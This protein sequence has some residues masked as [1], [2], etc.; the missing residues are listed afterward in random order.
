[1]G[2]RPNQGLQRTA[3]WA[4]KIAAILKP[5][6]TPKAFPVYECAAAEAQA[7]GPPFAVPVT[8]SVTFITY[9]T[10][11]FHTAVLIQRMNHRQPFAH[12]V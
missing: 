5:G 3:L 9:T 2:R 12:I 10:H 1:M 6:I 7:V 4:D 11:G 8:Q